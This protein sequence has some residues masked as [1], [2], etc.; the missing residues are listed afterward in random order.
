[1][2][3][4]QALRQF[5]DQHHAAMVQSIQA[6]VELETPSTDHDRLNQCAHFLEEKF[7]V[8][9]VT[10]TR[11]E[12]VNAGDHLRVRWDPPQAQQA[13]VLVLTHFD[14]VWPV[15]RLATHPFRIDGNRAYG[16]GIF[17]MKTSIVMMEYCFHAFRHLQLEPVRPITLLAT[18]DEEIGSRSSQALIEAEASRSAFVLVL[19]PPL[20]GGVLKTARKGSQALTLTIRGIPAHAGIEI[21]KGVSAIEEAAHQ[22]LALQGMTNPATGITVNAGVVK[23]G[24]ASNVVADRA[25]IHIDLRGWTQVELQR[26][27][28][29]IQAL[30]PVLQGT[31]LEVSMPRARPP[32]ETSSTRDIFGAAWKLASTLDMDLQSDRTGGGS[33]GNLTGALGIPT[34]DGLGVPGAGAHAD[35]EH[36]ELDQLAERSL[37]VAALLLDLSLP[38]E[39]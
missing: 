30:R 7:R 39:A 13:P 32:L 15:G 3:D 37:L 22:I 38:S 26:T 14:T 28:A 23:G 19:E 10:T 35:H 2:A 25:E 33:D 27:A 4:F 12:N 18:S 21:E 8:F 17:D 1:M 31:T 29:A 20:P 6:L 16:P 9:P 24:T 11:M 36:I 5:F 34:L